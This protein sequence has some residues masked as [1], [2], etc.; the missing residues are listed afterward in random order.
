MRKNIIGTV[1]FVMGLAFLL[2]PASFNITG[3]VILENSQ[4]GFSYFYIV[5]I[6]FL[7]AS[8]VIFA[9]RQSL[10]AIIIPTGGGEWDPENQMYSQDRERAKT[11]IEHK[12][13]LKGDKYFVISGHKGEGKENIRKGQSYSIYKFLRRHGIKPSQM[14]VEGKSHNTLENVLYTLKKIKER[15]E[16]DGVKRPWNIAFVSYPG[17]LKRL[18]DFENEAVRK[19]LVDKKDFKFHKI[20][21]GGYTEGRAYERSP[22][23]RLLH[24][25]NLI[26]MGRYK[27]KVGGIKY[28]RENPILNSLKGL[29]EK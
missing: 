15:E 13:E 29:I 28:I 14:I 23:R 11:A 16:K 1:L 21:T 4:I 20:S 17:H 26:S 6:T 2:E 27:S 22:L 12:K 10:D 7:F 24:R 25:Y 8:M 9:S 5:G 3:N 18:E 19:D